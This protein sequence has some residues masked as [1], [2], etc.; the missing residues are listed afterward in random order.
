MTDTIHCK[1]LQTPSNHFV[2]PAHPDI[3]LQAGAIFV[4]EKQETEKITLD[5]QMFSKH[6]EI[7]RFRVQSSV[8]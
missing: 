8:N 7:T 3:T 4:L 2:F 6:A 5:T 1:C